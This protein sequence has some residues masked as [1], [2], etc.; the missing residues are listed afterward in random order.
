MSQALYQQVADRIQ[1]RIR[2]G[3]LGLGEKL[4]SVRKLAA[5]EKVSISTIN[6][7]Y[8]QLEDKGWIEARPKSGYYVAQTTQEPLL[9]PRQLRKK[10]AKP[11][12][13]NLSQL[14]MEVQ[15][16]A[17]ERRG[18]SM[19]SAIPALD[20][21]ILSQVQK[22]YTQIS[23]TRRILGS[24]YDGPQG[25]PDLQQ[26]VARR[27]IDAGILVHPEDIVTTA[28]CQN[29]LYL[30]LQVVTRRGDIVAI[31]SPAYYGVLQM[32]EALGLKAIEIPARSDTGMSLEALQLAL[33]QWPVRAIIT[34]AN[35]SNPTGSQIPDAAKQ[36]LVNLANR[37]DVPIIEDDI[38]GE[39]HFEEVRSRAVKAFDTEGRVLH[40]CSLSKTLDPQLRTGWCI[41]G[42]YLDEFTHH[43]FIH[44]VANPS[45]PQQVAAEIINTGAFDRHLRLA[46]STYRQRSQ[47]L[48]DLVARHFPPDTRISQPKGGLVSWLE[49]SG[50]VDTTQLYHAAHQEGILFAPGEMFSTSGLYRN[51]LRISYAQGWSKEREQQIARLGELI[52]M[53]REM[54]A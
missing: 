28:G 36:D 27:S 17:A 42:R 39:L 20:F 30:C 53:T 6:Q 23:R 37:F 16:D 41:P 51:C 2:E 31:E 12:P 43:K 4:P 26:A 45:L 33:Q 1:S 48:H 3:H 8:A 24:G 35:Y 10:P 9:E 44:A 13:A 47:E 22:L 15:R 5:T 18:Q 32:I 54:A 14:V 52:N 25:H 49:L 7:A 21:P 46:R 50:G 34:V 29:A 11:R 38:Y 40:C 19:S